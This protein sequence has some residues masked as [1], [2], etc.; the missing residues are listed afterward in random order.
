MKIVF[1]GGGTGGHFY[2]VI[3]VAEEINK[4]VSEERLLAPKLYYIGPSPY[5]AKAL[6]ENG[7]MFRQS[8]AGKL[9]KYFSLLNI[10]DTIKTAVGVFKSIIQLFLIYPDVVFSKGGYASFPT[11]LA[12]R[13][14]RVPVIIH[15]SDAVPGRVT[16][17]ASRFAKRIAISYPETA[18]HFDKE[19]VAFTGN[20]VR[21]ELFTIATEGGKEFLDLDPGIP[22]VL[23]L[24][25]SQGAE[26]INNVILDALPR[27]VERYQVIHQTGRAHFK[28]IERTTD[29]VLAESQFKSR[30]MPFDFLHALA[31][32]MAA[33]AV[34]LVVSRAGSGSIFEIALWG[35]PSIIVPI[36][37]EV[38][39][40]QRSNAF[41]YARSGAAIVVEE[42]NLTPNL[43]VSEIDRLLGD[44]KL[45]ASMKESTKAFARPR[46]GRV[47]AEEIIRFARQHELSP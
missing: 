7:I 20:P 21:R 11:L 9:R 34:S 1:T 17:W 38:S 4:I 10:F 39:R 16:L 27:L 5:D 22:T 24:G 32:R 26:H 36:P 6:Y 42:A 19:R 18:E 47:I 37:E 44:K 40:D 41:S 2:P 45:W 14:L 12:A 13:L 35:V 25:G 43:L 8:P 46:A 30:Y 23:F 29:V 3:A 28:E 15:E 31:L 33:G